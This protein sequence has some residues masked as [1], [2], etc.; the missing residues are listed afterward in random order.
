MCPVIYSTAVDHEP[1]GS[2]HLQ[3]RGTEYQ[4]RI[5]VRDSPA[6]FNPP[7][8]NSPSRPTSSS[9]VARSFCPAVR[10]IPRTVSLA[11]FSLIHLRSL[12][13]R[14]PHPFGPLCVRSPYPNYASSP[15]VLRDAF[16]FLRT[17]RRC[18]NLLSQGPVARRRLL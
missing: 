10:Y 7:A 16:A 9:H 6:Q 12:H 1:M 17:A 8:N 11:L 5:L 2:K 4:K 13:S 14:K 18:K 3:I 15:C